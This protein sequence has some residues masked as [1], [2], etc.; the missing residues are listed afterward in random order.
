MDDTADEILTMAP[1]FFASMPGRNALIV[2]CIDLTLRSNEKSQ[3][4]SEHSSTLP[5]CT[6]PAQ[7]TSTS[8]APY[9][10]AICLARASTDAVERASSFKRFALL[11]PSS[12]LSSTS[13]AITLEPSAA[14]ASAI[15]RPIPCPAAVTN[16]TLPCRRCVIRSFL[17]HTHIN[18][19]PPLLVHARDRGE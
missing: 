5:W 15:A 13:V 11:L 17:R 9:S 8:S 16:A 19:I 12:L 10:A 7:L 14:N 2:R 1:A 6:W 18:G 3:S 4:C